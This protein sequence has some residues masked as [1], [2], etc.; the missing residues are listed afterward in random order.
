M[1]SCCALLLGLCFLICLHQAVYSQSAQ[2]LI[3]NG[4]RAV[5]TGNYYGAADAYRRALEISKTSDVAFKYAEVCRI[6]HNYPDAI[7]WYSFVLFKEMDKF[8]EARFWL[9]DVYKSTGEY[10]KAQF[11]YGKYLNKVEDDP[12]HDVFLYEKAKHEILACEKAFYYKLD[13]VGVDIQHLDNTVNSEYSEFGITDI[14]DTSFV[15][16]SL[17]PEGDPDISA[18][19]ARIYSSAWSGETYGRSKLIDSLINRN[20]SHISNPHFSKNNSTMY[21]CVSSENEGVLLS[22][23][24]RSVY[25]D[26][27][28]TEPEKLG[29][30]VNVEGTVSTQPS[31]AYTKDHDYL[32]FVSNREG[33]IGGLDIWYCEMK[34]DGSFGP[35]RNMGCNLNKYP[36]EDWHF[37]KPASVINSI[38]DEITPF[39]S[40]KD[41]TLYFSSKWHYSMGGFDIFKSQ[42]DF[43]DWTE[44]ENLGYPINTHD[45]ELYYYINSKGSI[46]YFASNRA[47]SLTYRNDRCCND[48]YSFPVPDYSNEEEMEENKITVLEKEIRLLVP[49]T[50]YFHNDEPNPRTRDTVTQ[51]RY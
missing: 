39:F 10:Q 49:L 40:T 15:F 33:G 18:Y 47:G 27:C 35:A 43:L 3:R 21:F 34:P 22:S 44:P 30:P 23:V 4:D 19:R 41:S 28:W 24:F 2:T 6:N 13:P 31:V 25:R 29:E 46:T 36:E 37:F 32:M 50:L 1:K 16:G 38:D 7:K 20:G 26:N 45:N 8:T 17:R 42:G 14:A 11:H 9:A 5:K 48:I 51:Y 12:Y